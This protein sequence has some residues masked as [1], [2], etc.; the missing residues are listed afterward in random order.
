MRELWSAPKQKSLPASTD[1]ASNRKS[2]CTM[3]CVAGS[4]HPV[5]IG[6]AVKATKPSE[7]PV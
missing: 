4:L 1:M 2:I 5:A 6:A 7:P 3:Q